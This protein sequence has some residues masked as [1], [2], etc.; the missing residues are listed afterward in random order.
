MA[1]GVVG[2]LKEMLKL[3]KKTRFQAIIGALPLLVAAQ[4][5]AEPVSWEA[6]GTA[7]MESESVVSIIPSVSLFVVPGADTRRLVASSRSAMT[8]SAETEKV[9]WFSVSGS[10]AVSDGSGGSSTVAS[11]RD[12]DGNAANAVRIKVSGDGDGDGGFLALYYYYNG[13]WLTEPGFDTIGFDEDGEVS[14]Q[15]A[16]IDPALDSGVAIEMQLGTYSDADGSFT[17]LVTSSKSL[18]DLIA[19]GNVSTGGFGTQVQSP[20]SPTSF[21]A[22]PEPHCILTAILGAVLLLRRRR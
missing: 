4:A 19:D 18:E 3:D 21:S 7:I 8:E 15:P 9:L 17:V 6:G 20:W 13:A 16:R 12:G 11:Y 22:V 10:A 2:G 5:S 14:W 1:R